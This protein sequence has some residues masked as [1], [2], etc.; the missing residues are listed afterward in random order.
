MRCINLYLNEGKDIVDYN[1]IIILIGCEVI[2]FLSVFF[3]LKKVFINQ[4]LR[5][6]ELVFS[7]FKLFIIR[8]EKSLLKWYM[9]IKD[10]KIRIVFD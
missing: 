2:I 6:E 7:I 10:S 3:C 4:R 9:E 8:Q 5:D 1:L